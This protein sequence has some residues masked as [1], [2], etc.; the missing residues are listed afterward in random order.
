MEFERG[1][2]DVSGVVF[3]CR[4]RGVF[5]VLVYYLDNRSPLLWSLKTKDLAADSRRSLK[6]KDL[7]VKYL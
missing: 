2:S 6:N 1:S 4:L 3:R 5:L 7:V